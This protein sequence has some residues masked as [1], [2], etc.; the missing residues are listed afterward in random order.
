[1]SSKQEQPQ[2]IFWRMHPLG[3]FIISMHSDVSE[4]SKWI[5][6]N[7]AGEA[8]QALYKRITNF[9]GALNL[10]VPFPEEPTPDQ[11]QAIDA[12]LYY[13][14]GLW[15]GYKITG[16]VFDSEQPEPPAADQDESGSTSI[17]S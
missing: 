16:T 6:S 10:P 13:I 2:S 8:Q 7:P 3:S 14:M 17:K 15:L 11:Q 1:M 5:T 4:M 12:T 9:A